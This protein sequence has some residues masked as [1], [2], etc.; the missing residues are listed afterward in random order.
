MLAGPN[1]SYS[2]TLP[3]NT[4][5]ANLEYYVEAYDN[6]GNGP[7]RAGTPETPF[8]IAVTPAPEATVAAPSPAPGEAPPPAAAP[9]P[10]PAAAV[11]GT[12]PPPASNHWMAITGGI[13]AGVGVVLAAVGVGFL[14]AAGGS[15]AAAQADPMSF[16]AF[17][18][19]QAADAQ[20]TTGVGLLVGGGILA[21]AGTVLIL[22]PHLASASSTPEPSPDSIGGL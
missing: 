10:A 15:E 11:S 8:L 3:G 21:I 4:V 14:V 1:D 20:G 12:S 17:A 13:G 7:G 18:K 16:S 9:R 19:T 6:D 22:V 5:D 2:A